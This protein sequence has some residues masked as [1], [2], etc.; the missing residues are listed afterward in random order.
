MTHAC[1]DWARYLPKVQFLYLAD[2]E[3]SGPLGPTVSS[4]F[5]K[6]KTLLQADFGIGGNFGSAD[7]IP[8]LVMLIDIIHFFRIFLPSVNTEIMVYGMTNC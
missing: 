8:N 2:V 7:H 3:K 6:R 1:T 5:L 4:M